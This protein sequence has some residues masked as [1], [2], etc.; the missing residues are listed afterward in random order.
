MKLKQILAA[1][2]AVIAVAVIGWFAYP[3]LPREAEA[4]EPLFADWAAI[5][6]AG[7]WRAQNGQ[8]SEVFDNGRREIA[9]NLLSIGFRQENMLQF[10]VR[11]NNY[12]GQ[13]VLPTT[14]EAITYGLSNLARKT[15]GGCLLYIT[16]HGTQQGIIVGNR[17]VDPPPM[18]DLID[19]ACGD[20]PSVAVI[21]SCFAGQFIGAMKGP[22]RIILTAARGDRTSFGC[23]EQDEFT[24]FDACIIQQIDQSSN[25]S[26]LATR[27]DACV[28]KRETEMKVEQPSEPQFWLGP[29][30]AYTLNWK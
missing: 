22:K 8:P 2:G 15:L 26:E 4:P 7:D 27:V 1:A 16:S 5:V 17:L 11:P 29:E 3:L 28:A 18:A 12:P 19:V 25:F 10:S 23:G 13:E 20:R 24:F 30:V 14:G 21:S 6:I 9:K